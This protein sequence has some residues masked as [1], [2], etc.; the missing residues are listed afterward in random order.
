MFDHNCCHL[1]EL[2][3]LINH[4]Y[5]RN[6]DFKEKQYLGVKSSSAVNPAH[7]FTNACSQFTVH[8][9]QKL[10]RN[11]PGV[12]SLSEHVVA[13]LKRGAAPKAPLPF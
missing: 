5:A 10:F 7:K 12:S 1:T 2:L 8:S 13:D 11:A 9:S 6:N 4:L 3:L